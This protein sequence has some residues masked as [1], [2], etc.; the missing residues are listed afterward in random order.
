LCSIDL[1]GS[2]RINGPLCRAYHAGLEVNE[3][4]QVQEDFMEG[5]LPCVAATNAFG[6]GVD[7]SDIRYVFHYSLPGSIEAYYQEVGRAGRDGLPADCTLLFSESDRRLQEFFIEG[8]NPNRQMIEASHHLLWK[9]GENPIFRSLVQLGEHLE[10]SGILTE[11][12]NPM[13]FRS[14]VAVLERGGA[15]DRL[16]HYDNLAEIS[17]AAGSDWFGNPYAERATV[18][19][20]VW[21]ALRAAFGRSDG[22][23]ISLNIERWANAIEMPHESLRQGLAQ[24]VKDD[25]IVF[26][27][28]FRGRAIRLPPERKPLAELGIDFSALHERRLRDEERLQNMLSLARAKECRRNRILRH[29]GETIP[30]ATCGKCDRCSD[31]ETP[32]HEQEAPRELNDREVELVRKILSG[33]ARAKGRCGR[34]RIIQMLLGSRAQ[35]VL[36]VG[37]DKLSTYGVLKGLRKETVRKVLDMLE[38]VGCVRQVGDRFPML[39]LTE[40]GKRVMLDEERVELPLPTVATAM[41]RASTRARRPESTPDDDLPYDEDL[42]QRLRHIR[43]TIAEKLEVPAYRVFNDRTLKAMAREKP[44][45]ETSLRGIPGVGDL[46]FEQ[47]GESFLDEINALDEMNSSD[48]IDREGSESASVE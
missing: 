29:F 13:A 25:L 14:A 30:D 23:P 36:E 6:M 35:G 33:V 5:R 28:P 24:L 19:H 10:E 9:L 42:F 37:F 8:S 34:Q 21:E 40:R 15:L 31:R 47:F 46:T 32:S 11:K 43:R 17:Q 44:N 41:E 22:E 7:K 18:R 3:R 26:I 39:Q 38:E 2:E 48:S 27:P 16:D 45:D 12:P 1:P 4:R 20:R